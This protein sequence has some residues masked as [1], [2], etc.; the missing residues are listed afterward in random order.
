MAMRIPDTEHI[1]ATRDKNAKHLTIGFVFVGKEHHAKLAHDR[2]EASIGERQR[3][4]ISRLE[5]DRLV[6]SK[7]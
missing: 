1:V 3:R 7:L 6:R 2:V 4:G 5:F